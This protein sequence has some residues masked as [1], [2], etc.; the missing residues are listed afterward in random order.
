MASSGKRSQLKAWLDRERPE[1]ITRERVQ[2]MIG[3]AGSPIAAAIAPLTAEAKVPLVITNAERDSF[4]CEFKTFRLLMRRPLVQRLDS[5][6][7]SG[8][9]ELGRA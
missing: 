2:L 1:L 8:T 6:L 9:I 5:R 3:V 4:D 7:G